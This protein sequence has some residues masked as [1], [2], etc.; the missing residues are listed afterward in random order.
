MSGT[1]WSARLSVRG[2]PATGWYDFDRRRLIEGEI[3]RQLSIVGEK[4]KK[5][6]RK[7]RKKK[8]E[9]KK[10]VYLAPSSPAGCP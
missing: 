5:K 9:E 2:P 4:G 6:K 7:R 1:Y 3:D 8:E 10:K